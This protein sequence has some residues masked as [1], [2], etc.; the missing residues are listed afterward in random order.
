MGDH[1]H[2]KGEWMLSYRYMRMS[3]DGNRSGDDRLSPVEIATA[4]TNRFSGL[5]M[6]P[7][8]LRVVPQNMTTDMHMFGSMYGLSDRVTLMVMAPWVERSMDHVTFAGPAGSDVLGSFTTR[9]QGL[10][11]ITIGALIVSHWL[12]GLH[13]NAAIS[14][15]TGSTDETG[16]VLTPMNSRPT[17]RLPYA[18]QLG[19]GTADLKPGFTYRGRMERIEWGGQALATIRLGSNDEGYALGDRVEATGWVAYDWSRNLSTS[20]R[21]RFAHEE[22]ISGRDSFVTGPVQT[23]DPDNYGG[24]TGTIAIGANYRFSRGALAKARL[25]VELQ[26]PIYRDVNGLQ[27]E[28]DWI[29]TAGLQH[30]F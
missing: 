14:L 22:S 6:Q 7:P 26:L 11:D 4:V 25:A 30:A 13:W 29:L 1:V 3:M 2:K 16:T 12:P 17:V 21:A 19:S 23:A 24:D 5:P 9:T 15:P 18:M 27:L 20:L 8:T 28:S 10:G